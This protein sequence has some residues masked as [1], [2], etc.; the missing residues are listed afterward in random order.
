MALNYVTLTVDVY[1]GSG[2]IPS[3]GSVTFTPS[4]SL[5]DSV[6]HEIVSQIPIQAA[7]RPGGVAPAVRLLAT[8][9]VSVLPAGWA[10]TVTFSGTGF[11]ASFSFFLPYSGGAAQ[12]LSAMAPVSA[13]TTLTPYTVLSAYGQQQLATQRAQALTPFTAALANRRF[14]RCN[15]VC[16][17]DSITEGQHAVLPPYGFVNRWLERLADLM[18]MQFPVPGLLGGGRGFIGALN[19][20]TTSF[21]WPAVLAGSPAT[22]NTLGPKAG[23]VQLA[24]GG[25][26]ITYSLTG[27][28]ADIMWT[29]VGTGGSFGWAL[30]GGSVTS[31]STNGASTVDGKITHIAFAPGNHQLVLSWVSGNSA[32]ID[33]VIEYYGDYAQG[34]SVHDAGH[35]GWTTGQW[36]TALNTG[37]AGPAAAIAALNPGLVIVM[38]GINDQFS[39]VVPATFQ[40]NLQ[41]IIANV[42]GQLAA[43][44]P[45]FVIAM[46]PPRTG[47]AGYAYPWSQ[48]VSAA[49]NVAAAD[50]SGPGGV[51]VVTV[52][53]FTLGP[54]MPGADAD[55]YG[56]WQAGDL[57]HPSDKGHQAIADVL[58]RFLTQG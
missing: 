31:V 15:V 19:T 3:S 53:D 12:N 2:N 39:G 37:A 56:F 8:D 44:Y 25:Q 55:A 7:F 36:V 16:I 6:D 4:V 14:A 45:S 49:W 57:V 38:L 26:T 24:S 50:T 28:S 41:S 5:T 13:A 54:R 10:W 23:F 51:S 27:D 21:T 52:C 33:G 17:G 9:N 48:Y 18:R 46:L 35:F 47:Q 29:Q 20:G 32:D 40:S 43:P 11:P 30:D 22:G 58:V 1:D 34:I 42:K